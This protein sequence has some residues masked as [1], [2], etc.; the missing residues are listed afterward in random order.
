MNNEKFWNRSFFAALTGVS[1]IGSALQADQLVTIARELANAALKQRI[2]LGDA[3]HDWL[4]EPS[5][6]LA[7]AT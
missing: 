1:A 4:A 5:P 3:E 6:G 2:M 7:A